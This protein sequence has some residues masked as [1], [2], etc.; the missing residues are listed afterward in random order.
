LIINLSW[1]SRIAQKARSCI[2]FMT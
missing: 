1:F 2:M